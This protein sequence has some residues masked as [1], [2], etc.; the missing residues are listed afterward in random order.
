MSWFQPTITKGDNLTDEQ[1]KKLAA[2]GNTIGPE[3]LLGAPAPVA[4]PPDATLAASLA[5][6]DALAAAARAKKRAAGGTILATAPNPMGA[7]TAAGS[8]VSLI[9]R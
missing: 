2:A 6:P 1:R 8:P 5:T 9:G 3:D 4:T 7:P